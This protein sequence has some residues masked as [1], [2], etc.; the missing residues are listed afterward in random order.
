MKKFMQ[1]V[2]EGFNVIGALLL[3]L[4]LYLLFKNLF[5]ELFNYGGA[6]DIYP[7]NEFN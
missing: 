2:L 6:G 7:K 5:N 1:N 3:G 4:L